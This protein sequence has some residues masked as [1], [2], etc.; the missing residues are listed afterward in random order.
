MNL[1]HIYYSQ[2]MIIFKRYETYDYDV[3]I[4]FEGI[5]FNKLDACVCV[6]NIIIMNP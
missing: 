5:S 6:Q 2:I 4:F 1:G 3:K